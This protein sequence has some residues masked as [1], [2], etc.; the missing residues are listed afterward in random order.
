MWQ[1]PTN[2]GLQRP[3]LM[4]L[5]A[6]MNR[7]VTVTLRDGTQLQVLVTQAGMNYATGFV[8]RAS[9]R[10]VYCGGAAIQN[11]QQA[12]SC[13]NQWVQVELLNGIRLNLFLTSYN[14]RMIGGGLNPR[15][16]IGYAGL[17]ADYHC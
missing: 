6:C 5:M 15:E 9:Y 16:L 12:Q 8:S 14:D 10:A 3:S 11:E 13:L 7:W 17:L 1:T 2:G 4:S